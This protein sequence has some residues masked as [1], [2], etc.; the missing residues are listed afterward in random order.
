M[1]PLE[2]KSLLGLAS[3]YAFRMV[4]LFMLLPVLAL[5]AG[6]YS[7]SSALLAGLQGVPCRARV[8]W[9]VRSWRY[10]LI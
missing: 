8:Q 7:G 10:Y 5:Y 3:L 2:R 9:P 1:N 6:D 4:G